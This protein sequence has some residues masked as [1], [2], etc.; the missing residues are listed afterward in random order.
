MAQ[1]AAES[2]APTNYLITIV[3]KYPMNTEQDRLDF[4]G[5][6]ENIYCQSVQQ[7]LTAWVRRDSL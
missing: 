4:V 3:S 1:G 6:Q 5:N 7:E 2:V